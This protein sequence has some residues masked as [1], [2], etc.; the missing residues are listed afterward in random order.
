MI[1]DVVLHNVIRDRYA[2]RI[3]LKERTKHNVAQA[4]ARRVAV[5]RR[6]RNELRTEL[7]G[8]S[9]MSIIFLNLY[10]HSNN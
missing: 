10:D 3:V 8:M 5:A 1:R 6:H 9:V 7:S 4:W 2:I